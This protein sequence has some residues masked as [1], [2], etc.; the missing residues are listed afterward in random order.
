MKCVI[1][2]NGT[3]LS[4]GQ[5]DQI[6]GL[7]SIACNRIN[8]SYPH[9]KWR[10]AVYIHP[11][12]LAPDMPFIQENVDMGIECWLGEHFAKPPRG[13]ME[14]DDTPNI[15][16]I[17]ECWHHT[18]NF[19]SPETLD[20][21]HLPQLCSFGGSVNMAMQLAVIKGFD[22]LILI[23]C[24][25]TYR[26]RKHNHFHPSYEHGNEQPAF[27]QA[28]NAFW[29]HVQ[30]LNWIRRNN[31]NISIVNATNGGH[32]ELWTRKSLAD[33]ISDIPGR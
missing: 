4:Y 30:A 1:V 9:T 32:L 26:D 2:G 19:D 16:W 7:P 14:M 5:L 28:R 15:H 3:S 33:A 13:V 31:K 22:E 23:G 25:L 11:E 27:Y 12:S 24:D 29:G 18:Y 21:W 6:I 17:K 20:E 10:P 8:L